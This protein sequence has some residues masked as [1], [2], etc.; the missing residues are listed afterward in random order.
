[1][2][3]ILNSTLRRSAG[4][5][6]D[7]NKPQKERMKEQ[8]HPGLLAFMRVVEQSF[9]KAT[10]QTG[11]QPKREGN[12]AT[13]KNTSLRK[14]MEQQTRRRI[15]GGLDFSRDLFLLN[16]GQ[17]DTLR[18]A[19]LSEVAM[20]LLEDINGLGMPMPADE[21][22]QSADIL[23]TLK[24]TP[25]SPAGWTSWWLT[26]KNAHIGAHTARKE[27]NPEFPVLA[28]ALRAFGLA[29]LKHMPAYTGL[30]NESNA[31]PEAELKLTTV[32]GKARQ[33]LTLAQGLLINT[34]ELAA[35]PEGRVRL[36]DSPEE[37]AR[38]LEAAGM[39]V[40]RDMG[41][42]GSDAEAL[43]EALAG[44][45]PDGVYTFVRH[46]GAVIWFPQSV[47]DAYAVTGIQ[48]F[49]SRTRRSP[50]EDQ[51][52]Y[53]A[54]PAESHL[55]SLTTVDHPLDNSMFRHHRELFTLA[56]ATGRSP[57]NL[58][59]YL[60]GEDDT[61]QEDPPPEKCPEIRRCATGCAALQLDGEHNR[62]VTQDGTHRSCQYW[63][64]LAAHGNMPLEIREAAAGKMVDDIVGWKKA[65]PKDKDATAPAPRTGHPEHSPD[66]RQAA[67]EK[68]PTA[69]TQATM[70]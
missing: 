39:P 5:P 69:S 43:K 44:R 21:R 54:G 51:Y 11:T 58:R 33:I 70:F 26:Q 47:K 40:E 12:K 29:A 20:G 36:N 62:P 57:E 13:P 15:Q 17:L 52:D 42:A 41:T 63:Q 22:Y 37:V 60:E 45:T 64:F 7:K 6:T 65:K 53:L 49:Q 19:P 1:M 23:K 2:G 25:D 34:E 67:E 14:L 32:Y 35:T 61:I 16:Q 24:T 28:A 10:S 27:Q 3:D 50:R 59:R 4:D 30:A 46:D 8:P 56:W 66:N 68:Q 18:D 48:S 55:I 9:D 31:N 38:H